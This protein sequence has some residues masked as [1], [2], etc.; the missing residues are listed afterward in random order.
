MDGFGLESVIIAALK[1]CVPVSAQVVFSLFLVGA[2]EIHVR[3]TRKTMCENYVREL[4]EKTK[5]L[6]TQQDK[7]FKSY[8]DQINYFK[9]VIAN[10]E[11][12]HER[13]PNETSKKTSKDTSDDII[14]NKN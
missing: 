6:K 5:I 10:E 2:I 8:E 3:E 11:T 9:T 7:L 12:K 14:I 4:G 13:A 1:Y